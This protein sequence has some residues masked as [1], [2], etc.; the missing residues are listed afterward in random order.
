M[1][2]DGQMTVE[3]LLAVLKLVDPKLPV[4]AVCECI[5]YTELT[6]QAR[7]TGIVIM[8]DQEM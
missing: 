5:A 1:T 7:D 8:L 6:I 4:S 3:D 2:K